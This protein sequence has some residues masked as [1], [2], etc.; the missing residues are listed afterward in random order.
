MKANDSSLFRR[1]WFI[2]FAGHRQVDDAAALKAVIRKELDD[3]SAN[4]NG[5]VVGLASAAA[6][7]DLLFLEACEEAGLRTVIILPFTEERFSEDFDD[8]AEWLKAKARI[9]AATW[10][11]VAPGNEVAP[12]AYH[13]VA[14]EVLEVADRMLFAW[15]GLP[16]RGRGGTAETVVDAEKWGMPSR[17]IDT[18]TLDVRWQ[19][20]SAPEPVED[21]HF[22]DLPTGRTIAEVFE[23]LDNRAVSRAP[24]SRWFAAGSMSVN[25]LATFLQ[26]VLAVFFLSAGKDIGAAIKFLMAMVAAALPWVGSR[27]RLQ[28]GW[29]EDR[30]RA[31]LL[32]SLMASHE[33]G[34]PLRPPGLELFER[35][36]SF[37]RSAALR[38]VPER[39]GWQAA[40]DAYLKERIDDQIG[41]FKSKGWQASRK[42]R[43]F[44]KVF[45]AASWG[46]VIFTGVTVLTNLMV[47]G[48]V[49]E[50]SS[51][52]NTWGMDFIPSV[53]PGIA[54]WSMA[55]ISIFE[56]KRRAGLYQQ[57]VVTLQ[58]IR[59]KLAEAKCSSAVQVIIRQC[60]RLLLNELWEWQGQRRKK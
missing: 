34:S 58:E 22:H 41:F 46:A 2:G 18:A 39:K 25:H 38:L 57:L 52:W 37:I 20:G 24:R 48:K 16:A 17:I 43:I 40:R 56:F 14:R 3:F 45:W 28:E 54:A 23:K 44:G 4:L 59:P 15:N 8:P 60:E 36:A 33:P 50:I 30:V 42:M 53:L 49:W 1:A 10:C 31:E 19:S 29:V 11:E 51:A 47:L 9:A 6:G 12:E 7:A 27:L 32:R 5:D 13:V 26:A 35:D 21:P 55:I